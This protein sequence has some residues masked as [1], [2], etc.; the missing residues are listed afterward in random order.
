M[1]WNPINDTIAPIL[2]ADR[3]HRTLRRQPPLSLGF[4]FRGYKVVREREHIGFKH[5]EELRGYHPRGI[6]SIDRYQRRI[7]LSSRSFHDITDDRRERVGQI[8]RS[9]P[10]QGNN[11]SNLR[12]SRVI[13]IRGIDESAYAKRKVRLPRNGTVVEPFRRERIRG[14]DGVSIGKHLVRIGGT[15][16]LGL[17]EHNVILVENGLVPLLA[18][19]GAA[20]SVSTTSA[21]AS[22]VSATFSS[23]SGVYSASLFFVDALSQNPKS[24]AA[25][26]AAIRN[27]TVRIFF[28][29]FLNF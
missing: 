15:V 25:N 11:L 4:A 28:S 13:V 6:F 21:S 20:V 24:S 22:T 16:G 14:N 12:L 26:D 8:D 9:T 10:Q 29:F 2:P 19:I 18:V 27:D 17:I 5:G 23:F 1:P 3:H 7:G